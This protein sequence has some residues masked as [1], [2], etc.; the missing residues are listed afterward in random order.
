MATIT[1]LASTRPAADRQRRD[2]LRLNWR[3]IA[4]LILNFGL[5]AIILKAAHL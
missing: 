4:A 3:L 5:W 2:A 1:Q